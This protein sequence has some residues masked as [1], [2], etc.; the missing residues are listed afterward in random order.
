MIN[1]ASS[2][3]KKALSGCA[4]WVSLEPSPKEV[5]ELTQYF[6]DVAQLSEEE[7]RVEIEGWMVES[8]VAKS[9]GQR[10]LVEVVVHKFRQWARLKGEVMA[11]NLE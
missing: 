9:L 7:V 1:R 10:V 6:L 4:L 11:F 8:L 5:A 3:W 2:S